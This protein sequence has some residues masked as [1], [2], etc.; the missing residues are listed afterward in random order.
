MQQVEER[1]EPGLTSKE[2]NQDIIKLFLKLLNKWYWFLLGSIIG[3][4]LAYV[5]IRYSTPVYKINAKVLVN[6]EKKGGSMLGANSVL[7]DLNSMLGGKSTVD[8]E[9]EILKTRFLME[10]VVRE[11]NANITYYLKGTIRDIEEYKPP[12][13]VVPISLNDTIAPRTFE[14]VRLD[15]GSLEVSDEIFHKKIKYNQ[16]FEIPELGKIQ[17]SEGFLP[18]RSLTRNFKF[19]ITSFDAKVAD[20]MKRLTVNVTNKQVTTIDLSFEYPLPEKGEDILETLIVKYEEASLQDKNTIADSTIS[21]IEDRLLF[22]GRELGDVEGNIQQFK[23][24]SQIADI[25]EQSKILVESSSDYIKELANVETQLSI[26]GSLESYLKDDLS[27]KRVL[28]SAIVTQDVVFSSLVERYNALLLEKDRLLLSSTEDNPN[29]IN[30][31]QQISNLRK[32]MTSNLNSTKRSLMI[33]RNALLK[34][35]GQMEAQIMKVPATERTYLDLARQQQI[36][37]ELYIFLLQKR[38]ET[39]ISKTSNISNSKVIDPPKSENLPFSPKKSIILLLGFALG[40]GL[41]FLVI[42]LQDF[43]N[44]KILTRE[45]ISK[46]TGAPI[47]AEISNNSENKTIVVSRESRSPISEQFRAL[48][49]NLSFFLNGPA[50][51]SILLTSG[52]PGEGKSFVAINLA[53]VLAISGKKVV[54]MEMDLRKPNLSNK[55]DLKNTFGFTNYIISEEVQREQV[56]RPSGINDN[57]FIISSGPIPPNPTETILHSRMEEL[58]TYLSQR[59]DYIIIDAPPIGLVTDAQ[60]LNRYA[61]LT[62]YIVRQGYTLKNQLG[63]PDELYRNQKMK[64]LALLVN[65]IK[66]TRGY[67]YGYGYGAYGYGYGLESGYYELEQKKG[68]TSW[69]NTLFNRNKQ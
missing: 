35:T 59:F 19:N 63:L 6:D 15:D 61:D 18:E 25:S 32:D 65:D 14:V 38:E 43:L 17:I 12:F 16:P 2:E 54:V 22:V 57:L 39:A 42:Y 9:A 10:Q 13:I 48:R 23:Q 51:K 40:I 68:W 30:L 58:M 44:D 62:L 1:Y 5:Y 52:M 31:E 50:Q 28:P 53:T 60:L 29:V 36:K 20:F 46:R 21:F 45:D 49:T 26:I 47:I 56:V 64:K 11:M 37:Q 69:F 66:V 55:L 34:K 41:P 7:G 24:K 67:G 3:L 33:T 4:L 27:Y 8:N